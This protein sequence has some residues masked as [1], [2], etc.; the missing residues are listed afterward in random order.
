MSYI[1]LSHGDFRRS[2]PF[3]VHCCHVGTAIKHSQVN[4]LFVILTSGHSDAQVV[5][6]DERQSA[7][8]SITNDGLNPV[9]HRML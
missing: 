9:W 6:R 2:K 7:L 5:D 3:D 1:I 8:M 4:P